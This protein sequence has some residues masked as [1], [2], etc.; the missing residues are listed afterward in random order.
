[1]EFAED[2]AAAEFIIHSC[3]VEG[4]RVNGQDLTESFMLL[5]GQP[6]Q[7]WPVAAGEPLKPQHF[8][9]V[10]EHQPELVVLGTGANLRLPDPEIYGALLS[11]EIGLEAMTT[12]AACRTYNLLAQDGRNVAACL[13]LP[14]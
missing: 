6:V 14:A 12:I 5:P 10:I 13:I 2:R 3:S 1:M 4:V 7:A 11:R 8:T 9:T